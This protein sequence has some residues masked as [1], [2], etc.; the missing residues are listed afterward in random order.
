MCVLTPFGGRVH[1]PWAMALAARLRD[2]LDVH[3]QSLWS[4]DGIALHFPDSDAPPSAR[5]PPARPGRDRGASSWPSSR[6]PRSSARASARTPPERCSSRAAGPGQRTP[7]WQQRLKAQSLLQVARRYPQFPIVLETY[8]ECLQDVFDLPALRRI[9]QGIQTRELDL[10]EVETASASP[11]ASSLLFDYVATYMYE[12]DTPPEERRAQ[13]L[14][15]DRDL[16]RELM[17]VEELRE[18][19]DAGAIE[20]VEASLR[21]QPRNADELHDLLRRAGP[22]PRRRVRPRASPRRSIRER[23]AIRVRLGGSEQLGCRRGCR[24]PPRRVR[25]RALRA[26]CPNVFLEPVPDALRRGAASLRQD[27]RPVHDGRGRSAT[28]GSSPPRSSPSCTRSSRAR[29]SFAA[30]FARAARSASGATRSPAPYPPRD[31]GG[32]A[33]RGRAGGAGR[34]RPLPPLV[35]RDRPTTDAARGPRPAAGR[36]AAGLALGERRAAAP[37]ARLPP[38]RPRRAV[39]LRRR[40]LGRGRA[41]PRGR[42]LPRGRS[43]C[44]A[45]L[46]PKRRR[47]GLR[48]HVA[49]RAALG[50][51]ARSSG[52]TSS[53]RPSSTP[54]RRSPRSGISSGPAR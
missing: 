27:A 48:P 35:A 15:L 24:A 14:S 23:R 45:R 26:A 3:A 11:F 2:T 1:A 50:R 46:P 21:P 37:R 9:L 6:S 10:V 32:A 13:A 44:S 41:R 16:L 53:R 42:V 4:D 51:E 30:S 18:L 28:S 31:A 38:G 20:Q 34:L 12:D 5:R 25:R 19:L 36:P 7:L 47:R 43:R 49:I 17:G 22:A 54:R 33:A 39:R 52:A 40:R 29:S 8:R